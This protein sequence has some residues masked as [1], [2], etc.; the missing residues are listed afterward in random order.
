M[1]AVVV[2]VSMLPVCCLV[3]AAAAVVE[4]ARAITVIHPKRKKE[5]EA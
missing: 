3:D 5:R 4:A 2:S 1:L